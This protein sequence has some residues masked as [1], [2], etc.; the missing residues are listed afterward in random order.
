MAKA[1]EAVKN[2]RYNREEHFDFAQCR[3]LRRREC[4]ML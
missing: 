3:L 2:L 1:I 4:E